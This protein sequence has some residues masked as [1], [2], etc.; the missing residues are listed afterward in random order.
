VPAA[1]YL[2]ALRAAL[3]LAADGIVRNGGE[4]PWGKRQ[5]RAPRSTEAFEAVCQEL[6]DSDS[7]ADEFGSLA[8]I[9]DGA[10][11]LP[12]AAEAG[13]ACRV[14]FDVPGKVLEVDGWRIALPEGMEYAFLRALVARREAGEVT[15]G[16]EGRHNWKNAV[17]QLRDRIRKATGRGLLGQVVVTAKGPAGGYRLH[18]GVEVLHDRE[19]RW[20]PL[21]EA[22]LEGAGRRTRRK[23][24]GRDLREG[25]ED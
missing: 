4:A 15:P 11:A 12:P 19:V 8:A 10:E 2:G 21:D 6:R 25:E 24:K 14:A 5:P 1:A 22:A 7:D 17:D 23:P 20:M 16:I 9:L 13:A 3:E 18:P